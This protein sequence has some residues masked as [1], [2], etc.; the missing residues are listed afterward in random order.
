VSNDIPPEV[1]KDYV[2]IM[3]WL[4]ETQ[5]LITGESASNSEEEGMEQKQEDE[6]IFADPNLLSYIDELCSKKDFVMQVS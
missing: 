5:Q 3:D 6:G 2:D 4:V 1:V